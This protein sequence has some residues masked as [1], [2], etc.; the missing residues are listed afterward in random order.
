LKRRVFFLFFTLLLMIFADY[1]LLGSKSKQ[2][3]LNIL[4]ITIDT[5]RPDRLSCY[6][7]KYL[8]TPRIDSLAAKGAVFDRAV[9]HNPLTLPSHV[10]I[11]LGTTPLYH[12]VHD[13]SKFRVAE[14][15][16]TLAEYLK[17]KE[18][19][20]AAFIG[21]FPLDS[22]FGL[23]QGFDVY[24]DSYP[25]ESSGAFSLAE[26]KAEEVVE[27]AL[28]WL[29]KQS[30]QWFAWVHL[31]DPHTLYS[32][33][34]P[35]KSQFKDD[36]YSGEVAYTD[37]ELGKIFDYLEGRELLK[38]TLVILTGDHGESLGEHGELTHGYFA[39]NSTLWVPLI[40][41]GPGVEPSRIDEYVSHVDIFP[42]VCD[43][44]GTEEPPF[45]QG[46]SLVPLMKGKKIKKRAIYFE[47][48]NPYF[49]RGW[50]PVRGFVEGRKKFIDSPLP[51]FYDLE[52]DFD[53]KK[54]IVQEINLDKYQKELKDLEKDLSSPQRAE[55]RQRIDREAQEKLRSLGYI[56]SPASQLK[57]SY[58]AEDDLKTLLPIQQKLD[59]AVVLH[60]EG[61]VEESIRL[62]NEIIGEKKDCAPAYL[63]LFQMLR[64]QGLE[65]KSREIIE[66]GY[67]N[68]PE[69]YAIVSSYGI[70]LVKGREWDKGIEVLQKGLGLI[71]FDPD[72]WN[73]LGIAYWRKGEDQKALQYYKKALSL[74]DTN[75]LVFSNLGALYLSIFM[76]SK[77]SEDHF[78]SMEYFKKAIE[79]DPDLG[80][81]YRGLG[82]A[83]RVIGKTEEAIIIW[84][85]ALEL[86]PN[87]DFLVYNL[88]VAHLEIGSKA[89][90]LKY[91]E[92][93]L[94]L[95]EKTISA[96]ERRKIEALIQK[97]K[98]GNG[99]KKN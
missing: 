1:S 46:V 28:G 75:A 53:E 64:E 69:N 88:G 78:Q 29:G 94:L 79:L 71:D 34:E 92:K 89:Q 47:S 33:P 59:R 50:A 15:F 56:V 5:I 99:S 87:D 20:T 63:Y 36:P 49:N 67:K 30:S 21:A 42:T 68:N 11:L 41:A 77:K 14:D 86:I 12:G 70:L 96:E 7:T 65:E 32:P 23:S 40:I 25:S 22:R 10:N 57:K 19:S 55:S 91:F 72:A 66:E 54:N 24:D 27:A 4:L 48:L 52:K 84:E 31:W 60:D 98:E 76:R 95:N 37:S 51:E 35:F 2:E 58:G 83:Y 80:L 85:K 97:C 26:R 38:N 62:L 3:D 93:Y 74:D 16:L 44:L 17:S 6:S 9:A 90:A 81:A 18:Y 43:I 61:Q 82:V 73:H 8:K 45:L 13:N 39:Y